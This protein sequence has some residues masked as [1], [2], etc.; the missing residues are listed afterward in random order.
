[1]S[2]MK[3]TEVLQAYTVTIFIVNGQRD[4]LSSLLRQACR[5]LKFWKA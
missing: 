5:T 4:T 3:G 1:M 2:T